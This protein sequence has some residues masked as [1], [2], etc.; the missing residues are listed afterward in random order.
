[1]HTFRRRLAVAFVLVF[2]IALAAQA[3][4]K[5]S[6][7]PQARPALVQ[8]GAID[9]LLAGGYAGKFPLLELRRAGDLG[10][11]TFDGLDGELAMLDGVVYQIPFDGRV[12]RPADSVTTPFAQVTRF[13]A[14]TIAALPAG[15]DLHAIEA[16]LDRA[17]GH[18]DRFAAARLDATFVSVTTRSVPR[19]TPPFR[20][21]VEVAKGQAV[22]H[23]ENAAGTLIGLRSPDFSRGLSVPGWHWHFLTRDRARGGHVLALTLGPEAAAG[24]MAMPRLT[25]NLPPDGF[26]GLDLA[27]DRAAEL[28]SVEGPAKP[29]GAAPEPAK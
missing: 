1:M 26:G 11:G 24:L 19:Q 20:P 27:R 28:K 3:A 5:P 17:L 8:F 16:A 12:R 2:A 14:G 4:D 7:K 22:F 23:F 25:V 29:A 15:A 10:L 9:A 13:R 6:T 18:T 21:L